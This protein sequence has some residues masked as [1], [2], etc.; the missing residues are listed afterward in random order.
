MISLILIM[1]F[2]AAFLFMAILGIVVFFHWKRFSLPEDP[3]PK[4]ILNFFEIISLLLILLN[5][6]FL[7]MNL[8]RR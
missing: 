8:L 3:F 6:A 1:L 5:V 2:F 7:A 4:K